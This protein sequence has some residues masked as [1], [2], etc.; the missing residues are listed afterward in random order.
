VQALLEHVNVK[1]SHGYGQPRPQD[2]L[3][4]AVSASTGCGST[5]KRDNPVSEEKKTKVVVICQVR[6]LVAVEY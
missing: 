6:K 1:S 2:E 4:F 3:H 5:S